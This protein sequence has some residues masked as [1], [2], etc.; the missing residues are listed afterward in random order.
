MT[1]DKFYKMTKG[2]IQSYII[3]WLGKH[4]EYAFNIRCCEVKRPNRNILI[5]CED[6]HT[7]NDISIY[8]EI[9]ISRDK[10]FQDKYTVCFNCQ[11]ESKLFNRFKTFEMNNTKDTAENMLEQAFEYC[12]WGG[13]HEYVTDD[14]VWV[15]LHS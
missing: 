14:P 4:Q 7:N 11:H 3:D 5:K 12:L 8:F 2:N 6:I 13:R 9:E 15:A 10:D 1:I